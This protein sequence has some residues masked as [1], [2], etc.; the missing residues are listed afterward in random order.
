LAGERGAKAAS[1]SQ[2]GQVSTR[3][4]LAIP[5]NR[6][7]LAEPVGSMDRPGSCGNAAQKDQL[8]MDNFKS[9]QPGGSKQATPGTV[10][11]N[12]TVHHPLFRLR[13]SSGNSTL[14]PGAQGNIHSG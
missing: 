4:V 5:D 10:T 14:R 12:C 11:S 1:A 8:D 3:G 9:V 6:I 13:R 2:N 7:A